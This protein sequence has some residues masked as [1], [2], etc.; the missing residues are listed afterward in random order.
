LPDV[1]VATRGE[2]RVECAFRVLVEPVH[3]DEHGR[4]ELRRRAVGYA[5][6]V[7]REIGLRA[8]ERPFVAARVG[9][10]AIIE[11]GAH[12]EV[13]PIKH[14]PVVG[15]DHVVVGVRVLLRGEPGAHLDEPGG[16]EAIGEREIDLLHARGRREREPLGRHEVEQGV[17]AFGALRHEV[18][19]GDLD[20]V[21]IEEGARDGG[22]GGEV[23]RLRDPLA[24][25]DGGGVEVVRRGD[26]AMGAIEEDIRVAAEN[27]DAVDLLTEPDDDTSLAAIVDLPDERRLDGRRG[28]FQDVGD[29][30]ERLLRRNVGRGV[31]GEHHLRRSGALC[32]DERRGAAPRLEGRDRDARAGI[33]AEHPGRGG[34]GLRL[35]VSIE[36][37]Q[38]LCMGKR[39]PE[40]H[41]KDGKTTNGALHRILHHRRRA[42]RGT[43]R[44]DRARASSMRTCSSPSGEANLRCDFVIRRWMAHVF[45]R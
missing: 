27:L 32:P 35:I 12:R 23:E 18:R 41:G 31:Q 13:F 21:Q 5:R 37:R 15:G 28:D 6:R 34:L 14:A 29:R 11:R 7:G 19:R 8:V 33:R 1:C 26:H 24:P 44:A 17:A 9:P 3:R 43:A 39:S 45:G 2:P 10:D 4:D 25:R 38:L 36:V 40:Q 22:L 42:R 20:L 30:N 16:D